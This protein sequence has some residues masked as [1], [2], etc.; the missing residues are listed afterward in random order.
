MSNSLPSSLIT[1]YYTYI[2]F[3]SPSS[4]VNTLTQQLANVYKR[5]ITLAQNPR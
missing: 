2:Y 1:T 4:S 5:K 3:V